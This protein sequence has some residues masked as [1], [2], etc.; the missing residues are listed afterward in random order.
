MTR[1][2]VIGLVLVLSGCVRVTVVKV[3]HRV[4]VWATDNQVET[5][6]DAKAGVL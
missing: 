1:A 4:E 5:K 6:V 3:D 2:I